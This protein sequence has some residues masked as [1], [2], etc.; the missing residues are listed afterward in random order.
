MTGVLLDTNVLLWWLAGDLARLGREVR[1]ILEAGERVVHVSAVSAVEIAVK[2]A[3]GKLRVPDDLPQQM[4]DNG[5]VELALRV[6]HAPALES[7]PLHHRD[8]FDRMLVA[9][10]IT[11]SLTLLTGDRA[12]TAYDVR[13]VLCPAG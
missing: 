8:P 4:A 2:R 10:A 13:T 3:I 7:L 1:G 9:Q 6:R 11:E 5:F 12:L